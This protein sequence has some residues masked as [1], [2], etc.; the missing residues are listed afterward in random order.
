ML[1]E[2]SV[3]LVSYLPSYVDYPRPSCILTWWSNAKVCTITLL[4]GMRLATNEWR[5][6]TELETE[7]ENVRPSIVVFCLNLATNEWRKLTELETELENV[8]PSIVVFCLN[9]PSGNGLLNGCALVSVI[10]QCSLKW[11]YQNGGP[12]S[13][14]HFCFIRVDT[15]FSDYNNF[16][17]KFSFTANKVL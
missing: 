6:L 12:Q 3:T 7:L 5:K 2:F 1:P 15:N 8:R 14:C 17:R 4:I 10:S 16:H 9:S 11:C 13:T